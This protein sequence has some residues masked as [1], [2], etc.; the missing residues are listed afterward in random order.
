MACLPV[1][2]IC[3][4]AGD[5]ALVLLAERVDV[6]STPSPIGLSAT[7]SASKSESLRRSRRCLTKP[8]SP[9]NSVFFG[10]F[11]MNP[12]FIFGGEDASLLSPAQ[13]AAGNEI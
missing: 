6:V 1:W 10:N 4:H 5:H 13:S 3:C 12:N 8:A 9:Q 2:E 11:R 7:S